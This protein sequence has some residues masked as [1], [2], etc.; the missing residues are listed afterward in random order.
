MILFYCVLCT[1]CLNKGVFVVRNSHTGTFSLSQMSRTK[2]TGAMPGR[3]KVHE[4]YISIALPHIV[5]SH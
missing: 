4:I 3:E 1:V 5:E 2:Y